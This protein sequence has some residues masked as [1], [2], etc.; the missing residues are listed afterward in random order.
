MS[1]GLE[2][3][4]SAQR[5]HSAPPTRPQLPSPAPGQARARRA[6][7]AW[8]WVCVGRGRRGERHLPKPAGAAQEGCHPLTRGSDPLP[9]LPGRA[10]TSAKI[11]PKQRPH[12]HDPPRSS[13]APTRPDVAWPE[14]APR[15]LA[16]HSASV[17]GA[18]PPSPPGSRRA[19]NV[20]TS[21]RRNPPTHTHTQKVF[22][23]KTWKNLDQ[24]GFCSKPR[25][26]APQDP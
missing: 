25:T 22:L 15:P 17:L 16:T 23:A 20:S 11:I 21:S 26:S 8:G 14:V 13:V 19:K 7:E 2:V 4:A 12:L 5:D 9:L 1:W 18:T 10:R 24:L 6:A 3:T